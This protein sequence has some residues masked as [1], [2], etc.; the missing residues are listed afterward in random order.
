MIATQR[1]N[2]KAGLVPD[3]D[4]KMGHLSKA[5]LGGETVLAGIGQGYV[6][7]T[8]FQLAVMTARLASGR[9]VVPRLVRSEGDAGEPQFGGLGIKPGYLEAV[10]RGMA[11][12]VNEEAGTG[13]TA[14]LEFEGIKLAGKTGTA[15]V[16]RAST[17]RDWKDLAWHD[18]DHALFVGFAPVGQPRYA[19]AAIV[20]HGGGGSISAAPL[21]RDVMTEILIRD[22]VGRPPVAVGISGA[23]EPGIARGGRRG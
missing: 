4:W 17:D 12:V 14:R 16:S 11:A 22:P 18:R 23:S 3:P 7:A 1:F 2:A 6:L 13:H 15:Q 9:K 20:E 19:V 10:R 21:V 8:P 5:W